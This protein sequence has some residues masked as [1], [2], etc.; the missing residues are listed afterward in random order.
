MAWRNT[1]GGRFD[2]AKEVSLHRTIGRNACVPCKMCDQV[3]PGRPRYG[4]AIEQGARVAQACDETER[5]RAKRSCAERQIVRRRDMVRRCES[6]ESVASRT[7][8]WARFQIGRRRA[9]CLFRR[10]PSACC[11]IERVAMVARSN[12]GAAQID[13]SYE[14]QW[15][16]IGTEALHGWLIP[17]QAR[18]GLRHR[19]NPIGCIFGQ[20][21][22][23]DGNIERIAPVAYSDECAAL[24]EASN[25]SR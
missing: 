9:G 16:L 18:R 23:A 1:L 8:C 24:V 25:E 4:R 20:R 12:G 15:I 2:C 3:S 14:C 21:R 11:N 22:G 10:G 17:T 6:G 13:T 5:M 7:R 19:T